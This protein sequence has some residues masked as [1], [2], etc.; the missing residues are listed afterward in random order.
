MLNPAGVMEYGSAGVLDFFLT[1]EFQHPYVV[2]IEQ[3]LLYNKDATFD[4]LG[5]ILV[6]RNFQYHY[7]RISVKN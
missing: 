5:L 3:V 2:K 4:I 1:P 7:K 6:K